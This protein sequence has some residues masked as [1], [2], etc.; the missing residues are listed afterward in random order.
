MSNK[1]IANKVLGIKPTPEIAPEVTLEDYV[2]SVGAKVDVLIE[3]AKAPDIRI[4]DLKKLVKEVTVSIENI[5]PSPEI[6]LSG[7]EKLL[8]KI[9]SKEQKEIDL[10]VLG[11]V[12][13]AVKSLVDKP[14]KE[15]ES[16]A[17]ELLAVQN[18]LRTINE[19]INGINLPD[20]DYKKL[21]EV[22]KEN[23]TINVQ[24]GGGFSSVYVTG[25]NGVKRNPATE[26]KQ[27]S[28]I[29]LSSNKAT[30]IVISGTNIYVGKAAI[31]SATSSAVWSVKRIET[32][33]DIVIKWADGNDS[34]DNIFDNYASLTYT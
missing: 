28:L 31:G 22:I 13:L 7:I 20:F 17:P 6:D 21:A 23:L 1:D 2:A 10:S 33:T 11:D 25:V 15:T 16:I 8:E 4:D 34:S 30:K 3:V 24:G 27:D 32:A 18:T 5:E 19:A 12:L 14:D 29:A 26:E 9:A